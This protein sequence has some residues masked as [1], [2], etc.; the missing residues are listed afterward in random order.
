MRI[1]WKTVMAEAE[2]LAGRILEKG[3][4]LN[5]AEKA[6][7]FFVQHGYDEDRLLRYLGVRASDPSFSRSRRTPGYFRGLR[8][9]WSGWKT[10][11]PPRWKGIAW[12]W[13]IR[14][15]KYRKEGM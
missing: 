10:D 13:A 12:G 5:E 9:I 7:K 14:I 4:D 3:I 15:A 6:L 1:D 8:E 2:R 11:L